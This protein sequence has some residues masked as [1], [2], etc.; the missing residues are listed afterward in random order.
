MPR[1]DLPKFY[2]YPHPDGR[3]DGVELATLETLEKIPRRARVA[4][5]ART[6]RIIQPLFK[7]SW[8]DAPA[9]YS[10]I[11]EQTI[12]GAELVA[13][14]FSV[15]QRAGHAYRVGGDVVVGQDMP[16][17]TDDDAAAGGRIADRSTSGE[18]LGDDADVDESGIDLPSCEVQ[19]VHEGVL[20]E[21]STRRHGGR[22]GC[23]QGQHDD[24]E[25]HGQLL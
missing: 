11:I 25:F 15:G 22:Q 8:P 9:E 20:P 5:A 13:D 17:R 24:S 2:F 21:A 12:Q 16:R 10:E 19:V 7:A 4:F 3:V 6:A 14:G 1:N 18:G 23:T